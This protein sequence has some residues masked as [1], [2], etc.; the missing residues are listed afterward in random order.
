MFVSMVWTG[1]ESL[2]RWAYSVCDGTH[3]WIL[4]P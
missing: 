3:T 1:M 2:L 4:L